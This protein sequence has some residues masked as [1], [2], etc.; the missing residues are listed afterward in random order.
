MVFLLLRMQV[1]VDLIA[2]LS[3]QSNWSMCK[4]KQTDTNESKLK[5]FI[6]P[7]G[8]SIFERLS[9]TKMPSTGPPSFCC[10]MQTWIML[11]D[12]TQSFFL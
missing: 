7:N 10:V 11:S 3:F 8:N 9:W 1:M 2:Y 5:I 12:I 4:L 6:Q